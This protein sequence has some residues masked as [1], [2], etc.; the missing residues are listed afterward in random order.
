MKM[1]FS[2]PMEIAIEKF[3]MDSKKDSINPYMTGKILRKKY[4]EAGY[5]VLQTGDFESSL[6]V[7]FVRKYRYLDKYIKVK[8]GEY[9]RSQKVEDFHKN[10]LGHL[11]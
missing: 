5:R 11:E 3:S 10:I 8:L 6:L 9:N 7:E 1:D 4:E 2:M